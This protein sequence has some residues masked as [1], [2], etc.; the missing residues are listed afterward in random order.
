MFFFSTR[1]AGRLIS[2]AVTVAARLQGHGDGDVAAAGA[3][4]Q[5]RAA[6][7]SPRSSSAFSTSSSVSGLRD[8]HRRRHSEC[9]AE[10][11]LF[12]QDIGQRFVGQQA[13]QPAPES[14]QAGGIAD[15]L[16]FFDP[17]RLRLMANAFSIKTST[18]VDIS[19]FPHR[20]Q[21]RRQKGR[22][23]A[24]GDQALD[25]LVDAGRGHG[26]RSTRPPGRP[27]R[28]R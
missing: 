14:A 8:Q 16:V 7:F 4:I 11:F 20:S 23:K 17:E 2:R 9:V 18:A 15:R 26:F 6:G 27:G 25:F 3:D 28:R 5:D 22:N 21:G 19:F 13:P 10:K 1:R 12:P 24:L